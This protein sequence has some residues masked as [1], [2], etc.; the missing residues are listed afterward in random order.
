M[1][2]QGKGLA[3]QCGGLSERLE[4]HTDVLRGLS[5]VEALS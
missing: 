1:E 4:I 2:G 3:M 5:S